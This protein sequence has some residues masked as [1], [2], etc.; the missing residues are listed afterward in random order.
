[1]LP[2]CGCR[3]S[4]SVPVLSLSLSPCVLLYC[5][6]WVGWQRLKTRSKG[7]IALDE[8]SFL[9]MPVLGVPCG[10]L[11]AHFS[12]VLCNMSQQKCDSKRKQFQDS[13][14]DTV[15]Q[16]MSLSSPAWFPGRSSEFLL[17]EIF[18]S[19]FLINTMRIKVVLGEYSE[20]GPLSSLSFFQQKCVKCTSYT[21]TSKTLHG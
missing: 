10:L 6:V 19:C 17:Q 20:L 16:K 13:F 2:Q 7:C 3:N 5:C 18:L 8:D 12:L 1:M 14:T 9:E 21:K 4:S 11:L 15:S